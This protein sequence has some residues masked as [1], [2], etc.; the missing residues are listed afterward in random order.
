M[1]LAHGRNR[2]RLLRRAV[3]AWYEIGQYYAHIG[4]RR[5]L[6][7]AARRY[8]REHGA[9]VIVATG[10]P[11]VLFR[12][13]CELSREF[14]VPWIADYRDPWS[15]DRGRRGKR[16]SER[17]DARL[18]RRFTRTASA[19]TTVNDFLARRNRHARCRASP[20]T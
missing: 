11:F 13:A 18:E 8:L 7:L 17:W 9:D 4:P 19:V 5:S 15:Q 6:Y 20:S 14:G 12:Y 3:T 2:F 16:I 10:E 1:L